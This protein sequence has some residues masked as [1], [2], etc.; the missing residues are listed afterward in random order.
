MLFYLQTYIQKKAPARRRMLFDKKESMLE[1]SKAN[2][3]IGVIPV[4]N[5]Q[6]VNS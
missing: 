5:L 2:N 6:H 4:C 1:F 3:T